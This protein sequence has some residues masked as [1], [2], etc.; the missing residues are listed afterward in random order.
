MK[1]IGLTQRVDEQSELTLFH[2]KFWQE[3][4]LVVNALD[5]VEA[6][7]YVDSQCVK[8]KIPLLDSGTL[9]TKANS[10]VILPFLTETYSQ[11]ADPPEEALPLCTIKSFPYQVKINL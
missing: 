7:K 5:N 8:Y 11:S 6:R 2:E 9:G 4:D 1:I 3:I 10:Q